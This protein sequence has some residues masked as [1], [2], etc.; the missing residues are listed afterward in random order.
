MTR[1]NRMLMALAATAAMPL[2]TWA[3]AAPEC[4]GVTLNTKAIA[5]PA[6]KV[7]NPVTDFSGSGGQLDPTPLLSTEID[8]GPLF[9]RAGCL[10]VHFSVQADPQ[11]NFIVFQASVDNAPMAGHGQF[12]FATP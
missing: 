5:L 3:Q 10:V 9:G 1:I 4:Q 8:V 12:L 11:D 7:L 6:A 2:L